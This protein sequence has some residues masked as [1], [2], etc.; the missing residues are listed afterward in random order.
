MIDILP[1]FW[2]VK[3]DFMLNSNKWYWPGNG[4]NIDIDCSPWRNLPDVQ[5]ECLPCVFFLGVKLVDVMFWR[6]YQ[7]WKTLND[8]AEIDTQP[9]ANITTIF[10]SLDIIYSKLWTIKLTLV[11][12]NFVTFSLFPVLRQQGV[13]RLIYAQTELCLVKNSRVDLI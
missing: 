4:I 8:I 7:I 13:W 6:L 5:N 3:T 12:P 9:R 11:L 1:G 10:R 2:L